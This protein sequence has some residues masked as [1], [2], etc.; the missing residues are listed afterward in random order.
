[1]WDSSNCTEIEDF[2]TEIEGASLLVANET[3]PTVCG[4]SAAMDEC[5]DK[6][7][8]KTSQNSWESAKSLNGRM[9]FG[10][11]AADGKD[12]N[13]WYIGGSINSTAPLVAEKLKND[14]RN[15]S[16]LSENTLQNSCMMEI[17]EDLLLFAGGLTENGNW[18]SH[19]I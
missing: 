6:C 15:S 18:Q 3:S 19:N 13:I 2:P 7:F 17:S 16:L 4:G 14:V 10:S 1:M 9:C 11:A 8:T 5:S 12:S